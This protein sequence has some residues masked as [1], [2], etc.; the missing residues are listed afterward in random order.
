MHVSRYPLQAVSAV[1]QYKMRLL[2][3]TF[4]L[5]VVTLIFQV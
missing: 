2:E 5:A 4:Y 1:A 3:M